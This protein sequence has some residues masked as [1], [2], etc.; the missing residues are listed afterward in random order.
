MK[1]SIVAAVIAALAV[2]ANAE[3][4][5]F[6]LTKSQP[7]YSDATGYG[8]DIIQAPAKGELK[9]FYFSVKVPDGNYKVTVKI[10][11]PKKAAN[12][13]VRAEDR[14]LFVEPTDTKKKEYKTYSFV[15]SKRSP[16]ISPKTNG[17]DKVR[18][19]PGEKAKDC[20]DWDDK[21][22]LEFNGTAPAVQSIEIASDTTATTLFLCGNST[23]TDQRHE[24]FASWGQMIPRWFD[25]NVSVCNVAESGLTASSFLAQNRLDKI[26]SMMRPGDYVI[27]EFGHN[28]EKEK[29]AGSGPWFNYTFALKKYIDQVRAKGGTIIFCTPTARRRFENGKNKQ[30]HGEY[31]AAMKFVGEKCDV[32]V[33]DLTEQTTILYETMGESDSKKL[34]VHYPNGTFPN[35]NKT[36]ADNTHFNPFGAYEV[37]KLVVMGLK[38]HNIPLVKSLKDWK[39]FSPSAP[40]DYKQFVWPLSFAVDITKP[41]GN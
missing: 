26:I 36:L 39:D 1:K 37:A 19:K 15:V 17:N 16:E 22:T 21:L 28:D 4:F 34:L 9:P 32:P 10:G 27:C 38:Q 14:R 35:Q 40:D 23:V 13:T 12:T 31:P 6:D 8:Y 25:T 18:L 7:T 30:T 2:T 11:S 41:D 5:K 20:L 24:P 3:T 33:I 29:G